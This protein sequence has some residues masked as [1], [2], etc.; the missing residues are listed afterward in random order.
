M[1][2]QVRTP[3]MVFMQPQRLIVRPG[4]VTATDLPTPFGRIDLR[5]GQVTG[6]WRGP[7]PEIVPE[8]VTSRSPPAPPPAS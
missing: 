6:R 7:A 1:E 5:D 2:T 8:R 3:Q 4:I